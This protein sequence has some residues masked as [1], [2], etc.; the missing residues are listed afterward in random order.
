[1]AAFKI[2]MRGLAEVANASPARKL[3]KLKKYKFPKSEESVGR[4][5]Y[6]VKALSAI[7]HHH[8]GDSSYVNSTLQALLIEAK[9]EKNPLRKAK[10]LN[11]HRAIKEYL[12]HFGSRALVIRPGKLLYYTFKELVVSAQPDLVAEENGD[13]VLIKLNLGKDEFAGGVCATILHVLYEAAQTQ[14][15]P[16]KPTG[17]ECLQ[18]ADGSRIA[19]PKSGFPNRNTLNSTCQEL[20]ALWPAA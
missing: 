18:T 12:K 17:I 6:Y 11:N 16:I 3:S 1:M 15:L 20:L 5:N 14:G 19:G 10:L 8:R 9:A 4:S 7:K 13:L 2:S